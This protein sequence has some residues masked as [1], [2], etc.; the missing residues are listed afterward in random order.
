[1]IPLEQVADQ[2]FQAA[3]QRTLFFT[4]DRCNLIREGYEINSIERSAPDRI[5]S[6]NRPSVVVLLIERR[7]HVLIVREMGQRG[8][9]PARV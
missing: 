4:S 7:Y 3:S 1:M 5:G 2:H 9:C 6:V 8:G